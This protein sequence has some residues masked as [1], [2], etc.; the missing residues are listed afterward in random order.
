[1]YR[2]IILALAIA[3]LIAGWYAL[4]TR[5]PAD[6]PEIE[7]LLAASFIC[8]DENHFTA[9]FLEG[10]LL[11]VVVAGEVARVLPKTA[12]DGQRYENDDYVYV[13]AGEEV[14][15]TKKDDG[16]VTTCMQPFDPNNAPVNFG[17]AAEGAGAG[18]DAAAAAA[19]SLIGSWQ[20]TEDTKF[21]RVFGEDGSTEDRYEG[22]V[23]AGG[24]WRLFTSA[25][26]EVS[27]PVEEGAVYLVID[28][29]TERLHFKIVSVTPE[30]LELVYLERGGAL[31][32]TRI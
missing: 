24:S 28:D 20:S 27:F 15:V 22:N 2:I 17:D 12:G 21:V 31:T 30:R 3:I 8:E 6:A 9:E 19:A 11:R 29:G 32:F 5:G 25:D 7:P 1:M 16:S 18:Q 4:V 13:F 26:A 23:V 10:D 14:S